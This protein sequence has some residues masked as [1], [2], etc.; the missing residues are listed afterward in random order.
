MKHTRK[1]SY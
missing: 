1:T